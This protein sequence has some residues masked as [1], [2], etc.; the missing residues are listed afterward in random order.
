MK[1]FFFDLAGSVSARD[2]V[3]HPCVSRRE[4]KEHAKFIAHRIG[5]EKPELSKRGNYIRVRDENGAEIYEVRIHLE[6][7]HRSR[8]AA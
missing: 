4:T 6:P 2:R 1:R 3:G 5:A 8:Y 7:Y